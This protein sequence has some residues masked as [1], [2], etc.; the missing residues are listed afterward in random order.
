MKA[1]GEYKTDVVEI[2]VKPK[3]LKKTVKIRRASDVEKLAGVT[4]IMGDLII[5]K[6]GLKSLSFPVLERVRGD[7]EIVDEKNLVSLGFSEVSRGKW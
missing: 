7:V 3:V 1:V 4:E 5:E 2:V 6:T